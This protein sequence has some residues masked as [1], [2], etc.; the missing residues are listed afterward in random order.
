MSGHVLQFISRY[1]IEP[2]I[3]ADFWRGKFFSEIFLVQAF[4]RCKGVEFSRNLTGARD[5]LGFADSELSVLKD[6]DADKKGEKRTNALAMSQAI[7]RAV[8][9]KTP[10]TSVALKAHTQN[11]F[12]S[13]FRNLS[14]LFLLMAVGNVLVASGFTDGT[15][16]SGLLIGLDFALAFVF[17]VRAR[18]R[19]E[20][21]VKGLLWSYL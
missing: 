18:Q 9:A 20:Q 5:K 19:G 12:C 4:G 21:Y 1:T 11:T 7:Y 8:D 3:K 10:D 2:L 15:A 6:S 14:A 16:K 17:F 13:L